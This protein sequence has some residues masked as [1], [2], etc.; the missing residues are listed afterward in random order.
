MLLAVLASCTTAKDD[1]PGTLPPVEDRGPEVMLPPTPV[2]ASEEKG[3]VLVDPHAVSVVPEVTDPPFQVSREVYDATF[4]NVKKLIDSLNA[5][6]RSRD[7][8]AWHDYLSADF[9]RYFSDPEVLRLQSESK[10]L[11]TRGIVLKT[12]SDY[13]EYVV[14][15]SRANLRLDDLFFLNENE[16]EAI[17]EVGGRRVTVYRLR[18]ID[19]N[20]KIGLSTGP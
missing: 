1:V 4:D 3:E 14:V 12:L 9:A 13:F 5:L 20:W 17:M 18:L 6:I 16:V 8:A 7:F 11:S 15:P 2:A 19:G 10:V